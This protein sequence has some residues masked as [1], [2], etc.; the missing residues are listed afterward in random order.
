M[1][2]TIAALY[3]DGGVIGTNPS[4]LGGTWAYVL[5]D[6]DGQSLDEQSGIVTAAGA[7]V[8]AV[9]NNYTE[10]LALVL[11]ME[12]LPE[13]WRGT[14]F[15]DSMISLGRLFRGWKMTGIPAPLV[16]RGGIAL[17]RLDLVNVRHV[18]LDGHPTRAQLRAGVGKRGNPVSVW[19]VRCDTLCSA[20]ARTVVR[21]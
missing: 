18:L 4:T 21:G 7:G 13:G 8:G 10:F 20:Q 1:T 19:N 16:K 3:A 9:T 12:A 11:G 6:D 14:I 5:V 17:Q 2:R 15:S